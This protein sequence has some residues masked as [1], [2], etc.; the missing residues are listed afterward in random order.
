MVLKII[1]TACGLLFLTACTTGSYTKVAA[2]CSGQKVLYKNTP[3]QEKYYFV[4]EKSRYNCSKA[5]RKL[6][7]EEFKLHAY[8]NNY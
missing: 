3:K 2:D 1:A 8:G 7:S 5:E 6:R 4:K